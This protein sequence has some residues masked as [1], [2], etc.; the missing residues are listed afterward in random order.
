LNIRP[1]NIC[2]F[3]KNNC[4]PGSNF[5]FFDMYYCYFWGWFGDTGMIFAIWPVGIIL[6]ILLMY[7]LSSTAD[8]YLSPSLEYI[9]ERF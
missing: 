4:E 2:D 6:L 9:T 1:S 3:S 8:E 5:N 7:I